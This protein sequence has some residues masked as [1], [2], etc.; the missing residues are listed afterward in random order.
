QQSGLPFDLKIANLAK[1]GK[2]L[3]LARDIALEL[4][5]KDPF[6]ELQEHI[7]LKKNLQKLQRS[8][9]NWSMIS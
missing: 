2:L 1:D 8:N 4:I 5:E 3:Q 9:I 7:V 6:L